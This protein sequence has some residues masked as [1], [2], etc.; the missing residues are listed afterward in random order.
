M[1]NKIDLVN[2]YY[3]AWIE[4]DEITLSKLLVTEKFGIRSFKEDLI[5][6]I[7]DIKNHFNKFD[8]VSYDILGIEEGNNI[9]YCELKLEFNYEKED[10]ETTIKT[11]FV[12]DDDKIVRVFEDVQNKNLTRI[13]CIISYDGSVYSGM[14]IQP[15]LR[16]IQGEIE[17]GLKFLTN[18][19]ITIY[20]SGRTDKGVH[21]INQVI[22]FDTSSKID[23]NK[24][25]QVLN[26]YLPNSIYVKSSTKVHNTFH[27]RY[28]VRSK[29]YQYI[30]NFSEFNPLKRNYEW[31]V[32]DFDIP[33]LISELNKIKGIHDFTSFTKTNEDKEMVREILDVK[34]K[35]TDTHLYI[36][37]IGRGFLRYMVRYI[38]GTLI[39]ISQEKTKYSLIDFINMKNS[40]KVKWKAP[41]TGLYLKEVVYYE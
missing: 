9:I 10:I 4:K 19:D 15:N 23:P 14:Q 32:K 20:S 30:I 36:S 6:S 25:S 35:Q 17:K 26:N 39:E 21:A 24:F 1:I 31:F 29:E 12:L 33:K 28:D 2:A 41:S 13:K 27:S 11:K 40:S 7:G 38:I 18:E 37:I 8:L 34:V 22:H 16:T 3:Q 5:F